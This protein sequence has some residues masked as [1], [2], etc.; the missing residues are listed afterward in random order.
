MQL[1]DS[2]IK[3]YFAEQYQI[4]LTTTNSMRRIFKKIRF[5]ILVSLLMIISSGLLRAQTVGDF[6]AITS[7][8]WTTTSIWRQ[9]NGTAWATVPAAFPS[10][11]TANVWILSGFTVTVNGTGPYSVG[12][13]YVQ[14]AAKLYANTT[15]QVYLSVWGSNIVCDGEIGNTTLYDGLSFNIE[16]AN[17]TASGTGIFTA[18]RIRK[19]ANSINP[20]TTFVVA[21]NIALRWSVLGHCNLQQRSSSR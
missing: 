7:G 15:A 10:G 2:Q 16:G 12:S 6:G 8:S 11:A 17:C 19:T 14:T 18:S 5:T 3:R 20:T 4:A 13:L 9:W 21:M 1:P